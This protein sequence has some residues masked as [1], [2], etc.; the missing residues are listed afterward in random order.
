M[1]LAETAADTETLELLAEHGI[2]FTLLAPHQCKRIRDLKSGAPAP[3]PRSQDEDERREASKRDDGD[4]GCRHGLRTPDASVD[5]T[6]PYLLRFKSGK[7]IAVFSST[8][9]RL[10][11]AIAFE[12][13]LNSGE[14]FVGRLKAAFKDNAARTA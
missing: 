9:A 6:R 3:E 8:M 10:L 7:S 11:V 1:W 13:L 5:T 14:N 4:C 2:R 12:G